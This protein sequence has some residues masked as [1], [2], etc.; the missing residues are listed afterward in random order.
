MTT[1]IHITGAVWLY[2]LCFVMTYF[3]LGEF[4]DQLPFLEKTRNKVILST[5]WPVIW[6]LCI[7]G[8]PFF[9]A[10]M[11]IWDD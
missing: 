1:F 10:Y 3:L 7:L 2:I 9:L 11:I 6:C 8:F 4:E 5:I